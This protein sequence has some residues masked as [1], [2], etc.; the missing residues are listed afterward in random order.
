MNS[1][2]WGIIGGTCLG[3]CPTI[4]YVLGSSKKVEQ[5]FEAAETLYDANS[6]YENA[7]AKYKEALKESNKLRLRK[8]NTIDKDFTTF[9]NLKIAHELC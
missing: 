3:T 2:I 5:L 9:V 6:D 7:I 1:R 4:T 8:P